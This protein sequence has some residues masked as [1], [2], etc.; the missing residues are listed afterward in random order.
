MDVI[1]T[2]QEREAYY[3]WAEY[4]MVHETPQPVYSDSKPGCIETWVVDDCRFPTPVHPDYAGW[5]YDRDGE[6]VS[7][8]LSDKDIPF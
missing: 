2:E 5:C 1:T 4:L 8:F 7:V 3:S 6:P